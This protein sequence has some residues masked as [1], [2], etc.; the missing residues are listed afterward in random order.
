M[1]MGQDIEMNYIDLKLVVNL[2]IN[3]T[4]V[5]QRLAADN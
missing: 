4:L 2:A 5:I 1:E 3:A